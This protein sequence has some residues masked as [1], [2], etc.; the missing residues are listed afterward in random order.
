MNIIPIP[1]FSEPFSCWSHLLA[2]A[3]AVVG[4][5]FLYQRGRGNSQR[6]FS[7]SV[8][9]FSLIFLFSMSGVYH[10]LE[11]GGAARDVF[12]RLDHAGI[13]VLIAG[14]FT[15]IH[16]ILFRGPWR[17]GILLLVWVIA[18]TGLVLEVVFFKSIPEWMVLSFYLGLGWV[19]MLTSWK[20]KKIFYDK[21]ILF[22]IM[23]GI[24]YSIG[25]IMDFSGWPT[26]WSGVIGPHEIFHIFVILGAFSHWLFIYSWSGHPIKN[27]IRIH[28]SIFPNNQCVA[29]GIDE[30]IRMESKT[31]G[32]LTRRINDTINDRFHESL[33]P[34]I[35]IKYFHEEY[36]N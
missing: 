15:P 5:Y 34:R 12:Q 32:E 23:G 31:V 2:A 1:G 8:F 10:L 3:A 13:W 14:T 11:P 27:V 26:L 22:L 25:A 19:G 17:W 7:L 20:F 21:D 16:T 35:H 36:L 18:I 30:Y 33:R 24:S 6:I 4:F 28:V 9:T 29:Y